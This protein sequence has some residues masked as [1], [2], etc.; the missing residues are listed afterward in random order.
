MRNEALNKSIVGI[1]LLIFTLA[2]LS[3]VHNAKGINS[4]ETESSPS[5]LPRYSDPQLIFQLNRTAYIADMASADFNGDGLM[6]VVITRLKFQTSE[7]FELDILLNDGN[8][9]LVLGTSTVFSGT[10]PVVQHP[11]EIVIAEFNDDGRPDIFVA[12]HGQD[13]APFPGYQN[14]L[15][16]SLPEGRLVDATGNLP[17]QST[18]THSATAADIDD[19]GDMDLYIGN[20]YGQTEIPPQIWLNDGNGK[21]AVA[22][23]RLPA[24]QTDLNQNKYTTSLFTD[25]NND[26]FP[27]LI[28]GGENIPTD[29]VVL[30]NDGTGYFSL[31]ANAI[32]PK[33]F[34]PTDIALDIDATDINGDGY[35]DFFMV[36][37]KFYYQGR[38]I[39]ILINNQDGTFTDETSTRLPQSD[40]DDEWIRMV[41]LID[42]D[43]DN[44]LDIATHIM[45][46]GIPPFYLNN[47]A[48][49]FSQ[50]LSMFN[51]ILDPVQFVFLDLNQDGGR[52]ILSPWKEYETAPEE[53]YIMRDLGCLLFLPLV[54]RN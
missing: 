35:Q 3:R 18:F 29:S 24:P 7:T 26:S 37:T 23:G 2:G 30:L 10:V 12:D 21:F 36:F 54:I 28:L 43:N 44:D 1:C 41:D 14:T 4:S 27:D 31:L 25:V 8:G 40:N 49:T 52:D 15:V 47:G 38:Y 11:R 42:L 53:Y 48:G 5:C 32:P 13:I 39:Q 50:L 34:A 19:D 20:I 9:S 33:P 45:G 46:G 22:N 17:Q 6:D 51:I 16:L